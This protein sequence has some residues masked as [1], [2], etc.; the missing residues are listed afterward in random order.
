MTLNADLGESWYTTQVGD[1]AALMPYLDTCNLACG[2]HGGDALT[3]QRTIAQA[4]HHGVTIGA[5]PSFP[6]RKNFG[7]AVMH[8]DPNR[9]YALILYQVG[10]LTALVRAEAGTPLHHL[11]PHGALYHFANETPGAAAAIVRVMT[12]LD[13]PILFGPPTGEL[14]QAA[15]RGGIAFWAEGFVDRVYEPSL[16]LRSRQL[17]EASI[18]EPAA[19]A[20][21]ARR[22]LTENIVVASDG[23]A[24]PL[25]VDTLC[26]H[27]DHPG[28]VDRA[29][30][31]RAVL[32]A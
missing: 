23:R 17:P 27:G 12:C 2:F 13:I 6:D 32:E 29:R 7:R 30:A 31:V 14:R 11:K 10:G 22:L 20:E 9:L 15:T 3:L 18:D 1:D 5:H 28:A 24:Y 8:L 26:I 21:Q 16:H 19:A 25:L 4:L